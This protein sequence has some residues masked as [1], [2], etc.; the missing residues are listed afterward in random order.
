MKNLPI[1][2]VIVLLLG[3]SSSGNQSSEMEATADEA[4]VTQAEVSETEAVCVWDKVSVRDS[5]TSK[6]KWLTSISIGETLTFL[7][8]EAVDTLEKNRKYYKV[9]LADGTEGWSR[10]DFIIPEGKVGVFLEE[11]NMY[12]RP[13]LLTKTDNKFSQMDIVAI[14]STQDDWYEITGKR[15]EGNWIET[16]WVK[17]AGISQD[18]I[19]VAVAK[20]GRLA[21]AEEDESAQ[22]EGL[23]EILNNSDFA[24]STF[25]PVIQEIYASLTTAETPVVEEIIVDADTAEV[26]QD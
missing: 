11:K 21:L 13:D 1:I 16:G 20:F 7:G 9:R 4:E 8:Q 23:E 12:K 10:N 26:T 18:A 2:I 25:I 6:G 19:D 24:S 5:P 3:C 22:I 14:R 15:E 17:G